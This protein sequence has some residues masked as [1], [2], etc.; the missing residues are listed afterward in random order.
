L[1]DKAIKELPAPEKG[2]KI[3]YDTHPD[4]PKGF[5]VRV[6]ANDARSFILRYVVQHREYRYTIGPFGKDGFGT[7]RARK[8]AEKWKARIAV[9]D[10]ADHPMGQKA[11]RLEEH[12]ARLTAETYE[13]AVR[14]YIKREQIGRR[15]NATAGQVERSL[16]KD[17]DR[18]LDVP[19]AEIPA[20]DI[21]KCLEE[22]RDGDPRAVPPVK[23]RPYMANRFHAYLSTFFRWCAEPGI[24]K[25]PSSPM[26]GLRRPWEGEEARDRYFDDD[27][28]KA[29][30]RASDKI[31]GMPGAFLKLAM[32]TGKRKGA[33]AA[34]R[35]GEIDRDGVWTPPADL[36]RKKRNKRVHVTPLSALSMRVIAP[37]R[38]SEGREDEPGYVF[39]GRRRGS[40]FD[41]GSL[42]QEKIRKESGIDDFIMH[43]L[44]H[45]VE[46]RLA[47][48]GVQ[49]HVR[50]ILL[51]HA[52]LRGSGAGY[53]HHHYKEEM[54]EA[55][56]RWS[57]HIEG[58]VAPE[59]VK[60][61][62]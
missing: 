62:R 39:A 41:P 51:D 7:E 2:N 5:G 43:A 35:W 47:E 23:P 18:W 59:G 53:D 25:V 36:R 54:S 14:D 12:K 30:W 32:L 28:L 3:Y 49:P 34:M 27:E 21:R 15:N 45:T 58:L 37:L 52:P 16:L 8:E 24:E 38:P 29:I 11:S 17:G 55:L 33:L 57:D 31:G 19:V 9:S 1:T 60:V 22:M 4:A 50:D 20:K 46:T 61:L 42:F 13:E 26:L 6:T 10:G 40:H 56:E 48:L 44:R